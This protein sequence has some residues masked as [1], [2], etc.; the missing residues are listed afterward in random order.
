MTAQ[1]RDG[2]GV[3]AHWRSPPSSRMP[4]NHRRD[5]IRKMAVRIFLSFYTVADAMLSLRETYST[6]CRFGTRPCEQMRNLFVSKKLLAISPLTL[7]NLDEMKTP[8][9]VKTRCL[10][11]SVMLANVVAVPSPREV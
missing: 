3:A 11:F 9:A 10:R 7:N 4:G 2:C 6:P 5:L 1:V 8:H